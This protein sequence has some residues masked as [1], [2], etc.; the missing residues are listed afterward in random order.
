MLVDMAHS[1]S[2]HETT[3]DYL[4]GQFSDDGKE[5]CATSKTKVFD[6]KASD[7]DS[8]QRERIMRH[9]AKITKAKTTEFRSRMGF[10]GTASPRDIAV[11]PPP[12]LISSLRKIYEILPG[13]DNLEEMDGADSANCVL[14]DLLQHIFGHKVFEKNAKS[15]HSG[16]K[17]VAT[18]DC[19][20]DTVQ[21]NTSP[22]ANI[23]SII[24]NAFAMEEDD[25]EFLEGLQIAAL[26]VLTASIKTLSTDDESSRGC[27]KLLNLHDGQLFHGLQ[28]GGPLSLIFEK[29]KGGN[30]LGMYGGEKYLP[31][32]D[33]VHYFRDSADTYEKRIEIQKARILAESHQS[34]MEGDRDP[35]IAGFGSD[36]SMG[37]CPPVLLCRDDNSSSNESIAS[38]NDSGDS[39]DFE[40][41]ERPLCDSDRDS[42][43]D[44]S[45]DEEE[46]DSSS[47]DSNIDGDD[48][49]DD[50]VIMDEGANDEAHLLEEALALRLAELNTAIA[51]VLN[52]SCTEPDK[53]CSDNS[54]DNHNEDE[55]QADVFLD[56]TKLESGSVDAIANTNDDNDN[57]RPYDLPSLPSHPDKEWF[58]SIWATAGEDA[59]FSATNIANCF[60]PAALSA[61][62][63]LPASNILIILLSSIVEVSEK[64]RRNRT[65]RNLDSNSGS[66]LSQKPIYSKKDV[67]E[68]MLREKSFGDNGEIPVKSEP[69][70][71]SLSRIL[72]FTTAMLDQLATARVQLFDAICDE[73]LAVDEIDPVPDKDASENSY[74]TDDPAF[75]IGVATGT[76][77]QDTS[78]CLEEKGM[79]RKA[80]AAAHIAGIR[81]KRRE[82]NILELVELIKLMSLGSFLTLRHLRLLFGELSSRCPLKMQQSA[83]SCEARL[84]LSTCLSTFTS[85]N[86]ITKFHERLQ[87]IYMSSDIRR[88]V[89]NAMSFKLLLIEATSLWGEGIL[90]LLPNRT[91][92]EQS[93]LRLLDVASSYGT[94]NCSLIDRSNTE[95][96][97]IH[98]SWSE[99]DE[100][101]LKLSAACRRI[102]SSDALD[103]I[104]P[105]PIAQG[106]YHFND[107]SF[108][109]P[110]AFIS[111]LRDAVFTGGGLNKYVVN[112]CKKC[113]I[114]IC[115]RIHTQFFRWGGYNGETEDLFVQPKPKGEALGFTKLLTRRDPGLVFDTGKCADSIAV[116][117]LA[118]SGPGSPSVNQRANKVWGTVLSSKCFE[119]KTGVHRWAVKMEKCERGHIF[120]G[121]G[122]SRVSM[123]T[124]VGGDK[125]G[126]GMI[127]TQALWHNRKKIRNDYGKTFR[128]GDTIVVT[129]D[130]DAGTLGFS[131]WTKRGEEENSSTSSNV[132]FDLF[133]TGESQ[134]GKFEDWGFAFEGL[135]LD[136]RLFPAI[137]M[138]QRDD[139][140][141]MIGLQG[142][143]AELESSAF[144]AGC[145]FYPRNFTNIQDWNEGIC[146][147]GIFYASSMMNKAVDLLS[148]DTAI[149]RDVMFDDI[150]LSLSASLSA[151][152]ASIP[153]L[154]GKIAY[155]L[156]PIVLKCLVA[157]DEKIEESFKVS[158]PTSTPMSGKWNIT[159]KYSDRPGA[160][161]KTG[162]T[163]SEEDYCVDLKFVQSSN[164]I[165]HEISGSKKSGGNATMRGTCRGNIIQIAENRPDGSDD[166]STSFLIDARLSL[167]GTKF[168]GTCDNSKYGFSGS[169]FAVYDDCGSER[170]LLKNGTQENLVQCSYMLSV[171][172]GRLSLIL[173]Q[174]ATIRDIERHT[175][176]EIK[177][178]GKVKCDLMN[179]IASSSILASGHRDDGNDSSS[180][181]KT[182]QK[183]YEVAD[184]RLT[185]T[186]GRTIASWYNGVQNLLLKNCDKNS[187]ILEPPAI[188]SLEFERA[189]AMMTL[190]SG[191]LGSLSTLDSS[192][193]DA[194]RSIVQVLLHHTGFLKDLARLENHIVKPLTSIWIAAL[195]LVESGVRSAIIKPGLINS[196]ATACKEHCEHLQSVSS[197]LLRF[198]PTANQIET[199]ASIEEV[200]GLFTSLSSEEGLLSVHSLMT[201]LTDQA[202]LKCIGLSAV[203]QNLERRD[204]TIG[205]VETMLTSFHSQLS[206]GHSQEDRSSKSLP[207]FP[208]ANAMFQNCISTLQMNVYSEIMALIKSPL[209]SEAFESLVSAPIQSLLLTIFACFIQSVDSFA[210]I[211]LDDSLWMFFDRVISNCLIDLKAGS[212]TQAFGLKQV[213]SKPPTCTNFDILLAMVRMLHTVLF[214]LHKLGVESLLSRPF[215][216]LKTEILHIVQFVI[217][218]NRSS[219]DADNTN[220]AMRDLESWNGTKI[221][222]PIPEL[223]AIKDHFNQH[224]SEPFEFP[225]NR[226]TRIGTVQE[227][228]EHLLTCLFTAVGAT[229]ELG[230]KHDIQFFKRLLKIF[231]C[232][233][234]ENTSESSRYRI[235]YLRLLRRVLPGYIA[236]EDI[237]AS[238]FSLLGNALSDDVQGDIGFIESR[239]TISL[240]R[241]LY[242]HSNWRHVIAKISKQVLAQDETTQNG[243]FA[244]FGGVPG[245]LVPGSFVLITPAGANSPYSASPGI[246]TNNQSE[247]LPAG[248]IEGIVSGLCR[249]DS[250]AGVISSLDEVNATC[251]IVL[252]DRI[253][254]L[255]D[256]DEPRTSSNF[257]VRVEKVPVSDITSVDENGLLLDET[258]SLEILWSFPVNQSLSSAMLPL[259]EGCI[260]G[261]HFADIK[262]NYADLSLLLRSNIPFLSIPDLCS[263]MGNSDESKEFMAHLLKL[264]S[265]S[266]VRSNYTA[267]NIACG[268]NLKCLSDFE[269]RYW[270]IKTLLA[271]VKRRQTAIEAVTNEL[272]A[273]LEE[274]Y[275]I[276]SEKFNECQNQH[277]L[278]HLCTPIGSDDNSRECD[279]CRGEELN[280]GFTE[281]GAGSNQSGSDEEDGSEDYQEEDSSSDNRQRHSEGNDEL[282]H[283]REVAIVQMLELGLPRSWSEFALRRVGGSNIE[284]AVHFCL[285]RGADMERLIAEETLQERPTLPSN[286]RRNVPGVSQLL[287]QL[288]EMGFP[289]HWCAEALSA[290]G[291][292][293]DEA[294]TWIL[295][296]GERLSA[297]D[298]NGNIFESDSNSDEGDGNDND[299]DNVDV[300]IQSGSSKESK[301]SLEKVV[302]AQKWPDSILCPVRSISGRADIDGKTLEV[303][304]LPLG[305]FSSVGTKGVLLTKGKWYY[306]CVLVTAGCIQVGWA[307]SSFSGE[308]DRGD[309]CGDGPSSWAYDGWRRYRWHDNATEWGC[310]WQEGDVVGCLVD[311]D[312]K[313]IRYTLNGK[314]EEIGMGLA[315]SGDGFKPCAGVYA[316]VSFNRKEKVCLLLGGSSSDEFIYSPPVGYKPVAEAFFSSVKELDILL[317]KE[318]IMSDK[319]ELG[320]KSYLCDFSNSEH[321]HEI[322]AWQH[323][324]YG[325]DA[326]VHLGVNRR[327][328]NS[329]SLRGRKSSMY[330]QGGGADTVDLMLNDNWE[331]EP[332]VGIDITPL[333][334]R[335]GLILNGIQMSYKSVFFNLYEEYQDVCLAL[336]IL[337]ARKSIVHIVS[338]MPSD[339]NFRWFCSNSDDEIVVARN[340]LSV[341]ELCCSLHYE[342]WVGEASTMALASEALGLAI[343]SN[344][345]S[346]RGSSLSSVLGR[347]KRDETNETMGY[348]SCGYVQ[349]LNYVTMCKDSTSA[350]CNYTDP[351]N[352][353]ASCA[354]IAFSGKGIG[355]ITFLRGG[356]LNIVMSNNAVVDIMVAFVRRSVRLLAWVQVHHD[357]K[358]HEKNEVVV[359]PFS[360][361]L[362]Q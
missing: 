149:N 246:V 325:S 278:S 236:D 189:D 258:S 158:P 276:A 12:Q 195:N 256:G 348:L 220:W 270:Y 94:V 320:P 105:C 303:G 160:S 8:S 241:Y 37:S 52:T 341:V 90:N 111:A 275:N 211:L 351:L 88:T 311:M 92:L 24:G 235:R 171:A 259:K 228:M 22:I 326:S 153:I 5:G 273:S 122:T 60:D 269:A 135:P 14:P 108:H 321:G 333:H 23:E 180:C 323:R 89:F 266:C 261:T 164:N 120:V 172:A 194:R 62:G 244:F 113:Y 357:D 73:L 70:L 226:K 335:L 6:E 138:Y 300:Q 64:K 213:F 56:T 277:H 9:H 48:D 18:S 209:L 355:A 13:D 150:L 100:H 72:H 240:I 144:G 63:K 21:P 330:Q 217:E 230:G 16:E 30:I 242:G 49:G 35:S 274:N 133:D 281:G 174:G 125:H 139:K 134:T 156:L 222:A 141:S 40:E 103:Y 185:A 317:A 205:G 159:V 102:H 15:S 66:V 313:E 77:A 327:Q 142:T 344:E 44:S 188:T 334:Q 57:D 200:K 322:F 117:D 4:D 87:K 271:N 146:N 68:A 191:G 81:K 53:E 110:S 79:V 239:E 324:Y 250:K 346:V 260:D 292:N 225:L 95:H 362:L 304:G 197:F 137:G 219:T 342:G 177:V 263:Q 91:L 65:P 287:Q 290:T 265:L 289:S 257:S 11:H 28:V 356:L 176:T 190:V 358:N 151:L 280:A 332:I 25:D 41:E 223:E 264:A 282:A 96:E 305:G 45:G 306:E 183:L 80:A 233:K 249:K 312:T 29:V 253:D 34:D 361:C 208:G 46:E 58:R 98:F 169:I 93:L 157:V 179:L 285:E 82:K 328:H 359:S 184:D 224:H 104:L 343:S 36:S 112:S 314:A 114:A 247:S 97:D 69:D 17:K 234:I 26:C 147:E 201:C 204:W 283:L 255:R 302:K 202:F 51:V 203:Q 99:K 131:L 350:D 215:A 83:V 178:T 262:T 193:N 187:V 162:P 129:L 231:V 298:E 319:Q 173:G 216:L 19:E 336:C 86:V 43:S 3:G 181:L 61:F 71:S 128:T 136:T 297:L 243:V 76:G 163:P 331:A 54:N 27:R 293:I 132:D 340:F 155:N 237:V 353:L 345:R 126:W 349:M 198:D 354:E 308:A 288:I 78:N 10:T 121:V 316:C 167:C 352:S 291:Q 338:S 119:P 32:I 7:I 123:K 42:S 118:I 196:R 152:P 182:L 238:L 279:K 221:P 267:A 38:I 286:R 299:N 294:L 254:Y 31:D 360:I 166:K 85:T 124:Y 20:G 107:T 143:E 318:Q 214:Q 115:G 161:N 307:D 245:S 339:F 55:I 337:Y 284:A 84:R 315:F 268:Q 106:T 309:G 252:L 210:H 310:R 140:A 165:I 248:G 218:Q 145:C 74:N 50:Q 206:N 127:G 301:D 175:S 192:Y 75:T 47:S 170:S 207:A 168:H 329:A 33:L 251:E 212:V 295:T 39:E 272:I 109:V 59:D 130:T 1:L 116:E 199:Q 186:A 2:R 148:E 232:H 296:N 154:S 101:I 229:P 67:L 347:G 227:Y